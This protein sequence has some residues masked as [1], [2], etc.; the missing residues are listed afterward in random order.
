MRWQ[1]LPKAVGNRDLPLVLFKLPI[2]P[3]LSLGTFV[4]NVNIVIKGERADF[5]SL[6]PPTTWRFPRIRCDRDERYPAGPLSP[7]K[8]GSGAHKGSSVSDTE[9]GESAP[10]QSGRSVIGDSRQT[11]HDPQG[12]KPP[13][14]TGGPMRVEKC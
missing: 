8:P 10:W 5:D 3:R 14:Q 4:G 13:C 9:S 6:R 11:R 12:R 7:K 2:R 1:Q